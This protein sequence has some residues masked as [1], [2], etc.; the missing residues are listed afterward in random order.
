MCGGTSTRDRLDI[1]VISLHTGMA[2]DNWT[3]KPSIRK[4]RSM[5]LARLPIADEVLTGK[6]ADTHQHR[7]TQEADAHALLHFPHP[8]AWP[9]VGTSAANPVL[10]PT[11]AAILVRRGIQHK[12]NLQDIHPA[13]KPNHPA[14]VLH[15]HKHKDSRARQQHMLLSKGM[16]CTQTC[17][18]S[19]YVQFCNVDDSILHKHTA[20]H[21]QVT[22]YNIT[23]AKPVHLDTTA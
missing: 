19:A 2:Y 20:A 3:S 22:T 12:Q 11:G 6:E 16:N 17:S 21:R 4:P 23:A 5:H 7:Q 18:A 8:T 9:M 1:P 14:T 13:L 15:L 10:E